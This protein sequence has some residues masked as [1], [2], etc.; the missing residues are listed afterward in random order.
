MRLSG[1]RG[2]FSKPRAFSE[3]KVARLQFPERQKPMSSTQ[4]SISDG[5]AHPAEP[6]SPSRQ[7]APPTHEEIALRAYEI[8][9]ARGAGPGDDVSDWLLAEQDLSSKRCA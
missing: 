7:V 3:A 8:F 9:V 5:K 2:F 4:Q 1:V 6:S